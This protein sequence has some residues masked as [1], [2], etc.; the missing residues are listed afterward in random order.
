MSA[1]IRVRAVRRSL[2]TKLPRNRPSHVAGRGIRL[3]RVAGGTLLPTRAGM[4]SRK[5]RLRPLVPR[6]KVLLLLR[7]QHVLLDAHRV[8]LQA[9]D[10]AVDVLGHVVHLPLEGGGVL[11]DELGRERLVREGHVHDL[12]WV[13]FGGSEIDEA[14]VCEEVELPTVGER[15]L[16][17]ELSRLT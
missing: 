11:D 7:C 2:G 4:W 3:R 15:E 17:D 16:L 9:C 10:L 6:G 14:A 8:E 1:F 12:C 13:T 5:A